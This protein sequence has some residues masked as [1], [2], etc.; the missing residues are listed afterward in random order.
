MTEP[1]PNATQ[2][3]RFA[4]EFLTPYVAADTQEKRAEVAAYIGRR[5]TGPDALDPVQV[6]RGQL[7]LNEMLLLALAKANG[8]SPEDL[9]AWGGEW[10]RNRSRELPE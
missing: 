9:R 10:L 5:L 2:A 3:T 7:Y 8:A 4:I 6:V 1:P